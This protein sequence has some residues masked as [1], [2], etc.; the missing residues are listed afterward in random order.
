MNLIAARAKKA[1]TKPVAMI[2]M[3]V[4][5]SAKSDVIMGDRANALVESRDP[6]A[7]TKKTSFFMFI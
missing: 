1:T 5:I 2:T 6:I 7:R 3:P 4:F